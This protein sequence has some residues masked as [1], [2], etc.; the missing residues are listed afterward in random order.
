ML[1]CDEEGQR[2][3]ESPVHFHNTY[4]PGLVHQPKNTPKSQQRQGL[5]LVFFY[6]QSQGPRFHSR[7]SFFPTN[8]ALSLFEQRMCLKC[9]MHHHSSLNRKERENHSSQ[10]ESHHQTKLKVNIKNAKSQLRYKMESIESLERERDSGP[11][12]RKQEGEYGEA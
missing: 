3:S 2:D 7:D 10:N 12:L 4:W 1:Q 8:F 11:V 6:I 5:D 9:A